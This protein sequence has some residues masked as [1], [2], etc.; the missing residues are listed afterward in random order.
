MDDMPDN[1]TYP[2]H[3]PDNEVLPILYE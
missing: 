3:P 1:Y 2:N